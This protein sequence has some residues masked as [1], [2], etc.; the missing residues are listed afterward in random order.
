MRYAHTNIIA[1]DWK[2]L[3]DFYTEVF[4][5]RFKPPKRSQAGDW[6]ARGTGVP[7]ASL[8]GVHLLLPGSGEDGP[9]L[10]IYTY[11]DI[12]EASVGPAN[13]R[14]F[15]HIAFEV[16]DVETIATKLVEHGGSLAGEVTERAIDGVGIITYVYA[17][18]PEGNLIEL[19]SWR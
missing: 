16:E 3:A 6:L 15:S 14:G 10:E 1:R 19:Q 12:E 13:R 17:R 4:E 2:K 9:T 5:C 7:G 11:G 18:D 8:E